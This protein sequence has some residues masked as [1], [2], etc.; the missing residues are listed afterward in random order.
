M[1][2]EWRERLDAY[3][4]GELPQ[5]E[6]EQMEAHLSNCSGCTAEALS[7][8]QFKRSVHAAAAD[9]FIPS[10]EFRTRLL[11]SIDTRRA[12]RR[13]L[14]PTLIIGT[15][16]I[17]AMLVAALILLQ[18]RSRQD[19][20]AEVV[21]LH[22]S[23]LASANPV[24]VVSSDRHTVKPWFQGKLPFTFNLPELQNS[25]FHLIGGRMAYIEHRPAAQLIFG[26]RK[27]EISAFILQDSED[28]TG[29]L[30]REATAHRLEFNME[31]WPQNGL[32]YILISDTGSSDVGALG[33][34]LRAAQ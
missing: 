18:P 15:A 26:I 14:W 25:D 21:D 17:A 10:R 1:N 20:L 24:D 12:P 19:V 23:A 5:T 16:V 13:G 3:A 30:G 8:M 7:W 22:V 27:H 32:R 33:S 9:A 2:C 29:L 34:L 4:D 31:T 6:I 11:N 28:L